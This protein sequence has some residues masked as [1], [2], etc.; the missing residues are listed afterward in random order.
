MSGYISM[1]TLLFIFVKKR[2]HLIIQMCFFATQV[3][4]SNILNGF[5]QTCI[6]HVNKWVN[7]ITLLEWLETFHN[8]P[9]EY[10]AASYNGQH[11]FLEC[12]PKLSCP[13][14][15]VSSSKHENDF[16]ST[17][18][19][20]LTNQVWKFSDSCNYNNKPKIIKHELSNQKKM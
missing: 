3:L 14:S 18:L 12:F 8:T 19:S 7:L 13:K 20:S 11:W 15:T 10:G 5:S 16:V 17:S 9:M 2:I 6:F 1:Y 4:T